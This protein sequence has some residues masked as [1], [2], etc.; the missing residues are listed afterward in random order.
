[1]QPNFWPD[2]GGGGLEQA[3]A[4]V[5]VDEL[6]LQSHEGFL[7]WFPAWQR[8]VSAASFTQLRARGAF[9]ISAAIDAAG[10]VAAG[11]RIH[12]EAGAACRLLSPWP[13]ETERPDAAGR[14]RVAVPRAVQFHARPTDT[15]GRSSLAL[16]RNGSGGQFDFV[17]PSARTLHG[18]YV[19]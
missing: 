18:E 11:V 1:M 3:G 5:A 8:G 16:R 4:A 19:W 7:S 6:M 2:M 12:S 14:V 17:C 13:D 9:V 15:A 10:R